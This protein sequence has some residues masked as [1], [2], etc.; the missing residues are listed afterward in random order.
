[1]K[2]T[3]AISF[4]WESDFVD[5]RKQAIDELKRINELR[6]AE[7]VCRDRLSELN[8]KL[9]GVKVPSPQ[10]EPVQ[11][12]GNK[13]EERWLNLMLAKDDEEKRL[14]SIVRGLR[15]FDIAWAVLSERDHNVLTE[16][17]INGKWGAAERIANSEHCDERTARRW[18][19]EAL[20][21]FTR[22]LLGTVIT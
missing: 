18:R 2:H 6:A 12:G 11:G 22:A 16:F 13:I 9:R 10:T 19:D 7:T 4:C 20:I 8:A 1:M 15:R 5:Y 3:E 17:Y 21:R 14:K